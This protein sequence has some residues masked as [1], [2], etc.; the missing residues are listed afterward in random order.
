[1]ITKRCSKCKEIKPLSEFSTDR[2]RKDGLQ[3]HC[4]K[5]Y[6]QYSK[7]YRQTEKGKDVHKR[8]TCKYSKTER[9]KT[10]QKR[11]EQSEKGK[12]QR[13]NS[14][15]HYHARHP[16]KIKAVQAVNN[17][18]YAGKLPQPDTLQCHYCPARA[19]EYHHYKGYAPEHWLD[20]IPVCK[21]CHTHIT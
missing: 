9:G 19:K 8:A 13:R 5:C 12:A 2:S 21:K 7:Q 14:A 15:C 3:F 6:S 4:K 18:I 16:Q 17:A 1:M 10:T 20:V 11:Y